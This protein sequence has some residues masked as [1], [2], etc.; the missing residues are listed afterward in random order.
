M[1]C[2]PSMNSDCVTEGFL[3]SMLSTSRHRPHFL[4]THILVTHHQINTCEVDEHCSDCTLK[5]CT[6][7]HECLRSCV[8]HE[9]ELIFSSLFSPSPLARRHFDLLK[10]TRNVA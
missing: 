5:S 1:R 7:Q 6:T 10:V 4:S 9:Q 3:F 2:V 8:V